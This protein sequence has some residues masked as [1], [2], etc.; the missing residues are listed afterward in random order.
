MEQ[1]FTW[2]RARTGREQR[3]VQF[4]AILIFILVL[5]IWA[6]IAASS[7]REAAAAR[8]ATAMETERQV[9]LIG[10]VGRERAAAPQGDDG[11]VRARV[12]AAAQAVALTT[13]RIEAIDPERVR[14]AFEP[15][16]SLAIYRW[17]EAVGRSGA[18]V[19]RSTIVRTGDSELVAAE[20]EVVGSP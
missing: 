16:D 13:A 2:W 3:L 7:F 8:L 10:S 1:V 4:A 18:Q 17:I 11:S 14:I 5:P 12:M 19:S 15:A 20:F 9:A 6:Y